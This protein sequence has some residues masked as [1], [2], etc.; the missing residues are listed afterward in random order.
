MVMSA[1]IC[2]DLKQFVKS[3][4]SLL[5]ECMEYVGCSHFMYY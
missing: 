2:E 5:F 4:N 1:I 3:K